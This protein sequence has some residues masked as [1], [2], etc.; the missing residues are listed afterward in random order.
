[1]T[2]RALKYGTAGQVEAVLEVSSGAELISGAAEQVIGHLAGRDERVTTWSPWMPDWHDTK[3]KV[4]WVVRG[5]AGSELTLTARA[6][7]A[8]TQRTV[9]R[10]G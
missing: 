3:A 10:L 5:A 8:G 9:I 4:E 7:R 6:Q 2:A 1:M